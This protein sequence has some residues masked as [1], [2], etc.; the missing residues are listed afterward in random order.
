ME[1]PPKPN[2]LLVLDS[3]PKG[4]SAAEDVSENKQFF[5]RLVFVDKLHN[6]IYVLKMPIKAVSVASWQIGFLRVSE[7]SAVKTVNLTVIICQFWSHKP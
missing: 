6:F 4:V 7:A 3:M 2:P 1:K 5:V